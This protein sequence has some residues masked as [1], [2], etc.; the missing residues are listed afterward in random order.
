[1]TNRKSHQSS[2]SIFMDRRTLLGGAAVVGGALAGIAIEPAFALDAKRGDAV[3]AGDSPNLNPP[4]VGVKSGKLRGF[5]D[6]KTSIFLGIPY[7]EAQRF[8]MPEP[9]K[10]WDGIRSAQAWG[11]VS[12]IPA[13]EKPGP[14]EFVFPHR[15]WL[16]NE[17]CQ[18]MNIWTQKS[19]AIVGWISAGPSRDTDAGTSA[20]E[21]WAV[22]VASGYWG[23]GVGRSL[24]VQ[25]EQHLR[26]KGFIAVTLW[27][28]KDNERAVKFYQ[29]N[30]FVLD[31]GATKEIERGGK[32]LSEV[33]FR[34]PLIALRMRTESAT[35]RRTPRHAMPLAGPCNC[36]RLAPL[37]EY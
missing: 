26:T 34:K 6:G 37:S 3:K 10:P 13:Q 22:Y 4:V 2:E 23:K 29:S 12:P 24:C 36:H 1:M 9:V 31:I 33:R 28:L 14:D 15:F 32:T 35:R 20:G 19:D 21:I 27:V 25:A 11:P 16:E 18:V 8:E 7:A 30:G 5:R 17:A